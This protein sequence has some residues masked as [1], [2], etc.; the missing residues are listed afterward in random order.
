MIFDSFRDHTVKYNLKDP[1]KVIDYT[2]VASSI[3]YVWEKA[4]V[5][6]NESMNLDDCGWQHKNKRISEE[7][8]FNLLRKAYGK[9]TVTLLIV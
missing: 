9:N 8:A 3:Q 5:K 7:Q 1:D 2:P 4:E 6:Y